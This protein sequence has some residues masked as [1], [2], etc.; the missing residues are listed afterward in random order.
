MKL[1][2]MILLCWSI[3]ICHTHAGILPQ[4]TRVIYESNL[5]SKSFI[6]A[7]KNIYPIL[8]QTWIDDGEGMP[9]KSSAPFVV[10]PA[11]FK[12]DTNAIH[13]LKI[14]YNGD[15]I[16]HDKESVYWLNLY[17]IP[18]KTKEQMKSIDGNKH[19]IDLAMNTQ[20]KVFYRPKSL[21]PMDIEQISEKINFF[22]K[23]VNGN[24]VL[25]C[26]NPTPYHLS[27]VNI[28]LK[29]KDAVFEI[30]SKFDQM[31]EPFSEK[32]YE[33]DSTPELPY[34]YQVDFT[35]IDD[36]GYTFDGL[37]LSK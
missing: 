9:D 6:I 15:Q 19:R 18:G 5:A 17:E 10:S 30:K 25:V 28:V 33:L 31:V 2:I 21:K 14:I 16:A 29:Q 34:S 13:V 23:E 1:N 11:V 8:V 3:M 35:L 20:L 32:I 4:N 12:M 26:N 22:I 7:N 36:Q 24:K 37:F 27:F